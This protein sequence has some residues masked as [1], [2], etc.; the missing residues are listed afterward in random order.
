MSNPFM[1]YASGGSSGVTV[2]SIPEHGPDHGCPHPTGAFC[3]PDFLVLVPESRRETGGWG[4]E[5]PAPAW[6]S[7]LERAARGP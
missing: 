6:L 5:A 7:S 1:Q 2:K 3:P 4:A